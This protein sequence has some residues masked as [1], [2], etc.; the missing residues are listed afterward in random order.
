MQKPRLENHKTNRLPDD[1]SPVPE[2][3]QKGTSHSRMASK[4]GATKE[5]QRNTNGHMSQTN[6]NY[7]TKTPKETGEDIKYDI[8]KL[9]EDPQKLSRWMEQRMELQETNT[10]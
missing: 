3:S 7:K 10:Q 9:R 6:E 2:L 5:A 8:D 4:H 1:Q